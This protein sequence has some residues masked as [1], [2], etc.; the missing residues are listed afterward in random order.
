[1]DSLGV[2][3]S[4]ENQFTVGCSAGLNEVTGELRHSSRKSMQQNLTLNPA[5]CVQKLPFS[6]S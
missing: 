6:V 2:L 5:L 1:M 3:D 4:H